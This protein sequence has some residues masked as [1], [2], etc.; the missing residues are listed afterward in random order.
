MRAVLEYAAFLQ[1]LRAGVGISTEQL[2]GLVGALRSS[3]S[4]AAS[5]PLVAALRVWALAEAIRAG[6]KQAVQ[7]SSDSPF[8]LLAS[9]G[10]DLAQ[11]VV[12]GGCL[13]VLAAEKCIPL[14]VTQ[15]E[16]V[17]KPTSHAVAVDQLM[18]AA[19]CAWD[20]DNGLLCL[21][22]TYL[23][24]Q[25]MPRQE[26]GRLATQSAAA[27]QLVKL[28]G[29][30]ARDARGSQGHCCGLQ[31]LPELV[32]KLMQLAVDC[33]Q[34]SAEFSRL[35]SSPGLGLIDVLEEFRELCATHRPW[36]HAD[37]AAGIKQLAGV[38]KKL[39]AQLLSGWHM[40][41]C[42][43]SLTSQSSWLRSISGYTAGRWQ[44]CRSS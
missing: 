11:L 43:T 5:Q 25:L 13:Q 31:E 38:I 14:L 12:G 24:Q 7:A 35:L 3:S 39:T 20:N 30:I 42:M 10:N 23:L 9:I 33:M 16:L 41:L 37:L 32:Q 44:G 6:A 8:M 29:V 15:L 1:L 28:L 22:L 18:V 36:Q 19:C 34:R 4:Q 26:E 27:Q 21:N 40:T 17:R 2:Q